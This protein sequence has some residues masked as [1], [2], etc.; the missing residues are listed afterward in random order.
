MSSSSWCHKGSLPKSEAP[1][2]QPRNPYPRARNPNPYNLN[3][4]PYRYCDTRTTP[5]VKPSPLRLNAPR[6]VSGI[7]PTEVRFRLQSLRCQMRQALQATRA[8]LQGC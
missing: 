4:R 8:V 1:K 2:P 5:I 7:Y 6:A 3:H